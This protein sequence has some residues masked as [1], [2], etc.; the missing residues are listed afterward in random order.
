MN[1]GMNEPVVMVEGSRGRRELHGK[2]VKVGRVW[3]EIQPEGWADGR[4]IRFRLDTQTD[5][6]KIGAPPHFYT[7]GQWAE[8]Q[9]REEAFKLLREQGISVDAGS[10]WRGR[11][12]ELADLVRKV[13]ATDDDAMEP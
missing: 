3:I 5:G 7:L 6:S 13:V 2:V 1:V 4:T 8:R 11:E 9:Q 12:A 10:P